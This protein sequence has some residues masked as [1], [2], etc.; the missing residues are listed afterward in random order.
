MLNKQDLKLIKNT[1]LE[2]IEPIMAAFSHDFTGQGKKIDKLDKKVDKI[3]K[4]V[5]DVN[6]R[7]EATY[8]KLVSL[9]RRIM[10]IEDRL[11]EIVKQDEKEFNNIKKDL[12]SLI[13]QR[14]IDS[15]K[16][17]NIEAR[18]NKLELKIS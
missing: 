17:I 8:A 7:Q 11:T 1:I 5:T 13:K 12:A 2:V 9:D 16:L 3:D 4:K 18:L 6:I 15:G 10:Y 14:D